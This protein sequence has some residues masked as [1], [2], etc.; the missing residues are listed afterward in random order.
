[1]RVGVA[2]QSKPLSFGKSLAARA[3]DKYARVPKRLLT[4]VELWV[5]KWN[6]PQIARMNTDV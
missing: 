3:N 1:M 4:T 6:Q 5:K 2:A